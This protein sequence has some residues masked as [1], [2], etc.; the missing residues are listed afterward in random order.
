MLA[1]R[2]DQLRPRQTAGLDRFLN[3]LDFLRRERAPGQEFWCSVPHQHAA[4]PNGPPYHLK[5]V[6]S[7]PLLFRDKKNLQVGPSCSISSAKQTRRQ[8][9]LMQWMEETSTAV[10][11]RGKDR[12]IW[13]R[14]TTVQHQGHGV[15]PAT[16][17]KKTEWKAGTLSGCCCRSGHFARTGHGLPYGEFRGGFADKPRPAPL[18]CQAFH[19]AGDSRHDN[20]R[21]GFPRPASRGCARDLG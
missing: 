10:E 19:I 16:P 17:R 4:A 18:F 7:C 2:V 21:W 13:Q 12:P 14:K 6:F 8:S 11:K 5:T 15:A 9:C 3:V 20:F 1:D